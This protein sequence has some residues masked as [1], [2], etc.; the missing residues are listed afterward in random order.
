M[1]S[2]APPCLGCCWCGF[3]TCK[4]HY[5]GR[6]Q[7]RTSDCLLCNPNSWHILQFCSSSTGTAVCWLAAGG[8]EWPFSPSFDGFTSPSVGPKHLQPGCVPSMQVLK[9]L[10]VFHSV[11]TAISFIHS[12]IYL[13]QKEMP[14][15][16]AR[17]TRTAP[18]EEDKTL[19]VF[20]LCCISCL[21]KNT[22]SVLVSQ[23]KTDFGRKITWHCIFVLLVNTR[24]LKRVAFSFLLILLLMALLKTPHQSHHSSWSSPGQF[25]GSPGWTKAGTS[26]AAPAEFLLPAAE[27]WAPEDEH[28]HTA[29]TTVL[30]LHF[31]EARGKG[32]VLSMS[33]CCAHLPGNCCPGSPLSH[34]H[35]CPDEKG[36]LP[37]NYKH[38]ILRMCSTLTLNGCKS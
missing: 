38:W 22:N 1:L 13:Q 12:D 36:L 20:L 6:R 2:R 34:R 15:G 4:N 24:L 23:L 35:L 10:E 11:L 19:C 16:T 18:C 9:C 7:Q 5:T 8:S 30:E 31:C 26:Q 37:Q 3:L 17:V 14:A 25:L 33:C 21:K 32:Q 29:A 28:A 27:E